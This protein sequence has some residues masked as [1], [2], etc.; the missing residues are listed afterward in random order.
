NWI[1]PLMIVNSILLMAPAV[2]GSLGDVRLAIP[3]TA[4][5]TLIFLQQSYRSSLPRLPY[6]TYLDDLFSCSYIISMALFAL[7]TWGTNAYS[8]A[9]PE[10]KER[11][12]SRINRTDRL[13]Q[14]SSCFALLS[15]AILGWIFK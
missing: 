5:L 14:I 9:T 8:M 2:E 11:T 7:F 4:L 6:T 13:F 1:L 10:E 12:M 15:V 3:S